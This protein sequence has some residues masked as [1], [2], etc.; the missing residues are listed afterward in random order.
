MKKIIYS[1]LALFL[2][3]TTSCEPLEDVY[4][5]LDATSSE[6]IKGDTDYTLISEDYTNEEDEG[7]FNLSNEFF[8]TL[9]QSEQLLPVL[10]EKKYPM[11]GK[12]SIVRLTFK[13]SQLYKKIDYT[14]T[15]EDYLNFGATDNS[16]ASEEEVLNFIGVNFA[17]EK[18][19]TVVDLT[20]KGALE[21]YELTN[22]DYDSVG[23]G[24]F[25]N[26]DIRPGANE[27]TLESRRVKIQTILLANFP[28]AEN[29]TAFKVD[30]KA[31]NGSGVEDLS[32]NL[33]L[34]II[35]FP[36]TP[37]D[38]ELT[39]DDYDSVG[40][41]R[42]NNFD[43]RPG[44]A[45]ET[46]EARRA[47]IETILLANFPTAVQGDI[48]NVSYK[49]FN[50]SAGEDNM[51][52][53]LDA[54]GGYSIFDTEVYN[55]YADSTVDQTTRYT[56]GNVWERPYVLTSDDYR[57]LGQ[58]FDNFSGST[59]E[60][61]H[62][63][64]RL[65]EVFLAN[66]DENTY[67]AVGDCKTLQYDTFS[68]GTITTQNISFVFD[69]TSWSSS[70]ELTVQYGFDGSVW[71]PDNTI[72]Y[73]LTGADYVLVGNGRFNNFDIR[74]G[75]DEETVEARRAKISTILLN[76][77]E[78]LGEGQKFVV[79]YNVWMPGDGVLEMSLIHDGT[80]YVLNE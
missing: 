31:F 59:I 11:F 76:N 57:E 54:T 78:T 66:Q 33:I 65:L 47:K 12:G 56:L 60:D 17:T 77:F 51:Y 62:E 32:M 29:G 50:G 14:V 15:A 42:F 49:T 53:I 23:N 68:S 35:D 41:G 38:Y 16:F 73:T 39:N 44:R 43:I 48:F 9:E 1:L 19:G 58:R 22:D 80:E 10:L 4:E 21:S 34:S 61:R 5:E 18:K 71:E 13:A 30:Y 55:I 26:F 8:E 28:D 52:V 36:T 27:E 7:G 2:V 24:R 69:G 79:S 6:V 67:A 37:Q 40:N 20:F 72:L 64:Q 63:A 3:F 46:L 70:R 75:S 45:E 25:N 74:E